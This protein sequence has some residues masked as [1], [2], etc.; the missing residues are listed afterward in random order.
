MDSLTQACLGALIGAV[1]APAAQRRRG[2]LYGAALGTLPD[3]DVLIPYANP[4]DALVQ[5]R[6][7]SHS[8][9][10]LTLLAPVLHWLCARFDRALKD[11]A[12][13]WRLLFLLALIT[14]PL[15]D[16]FT[17][18]GTQLLWPFDRTPYALASIFIIDP[19]VTLPMLLALIWVARAP[20]LPAILA[21]YVALAWSCLYLVF[22]LL[23]QQLIR[24]R[25]EASLA[26]EEAVEERAIFV[27]A[28]P[29]TGLL[30][31]VVVREPTLFREGYV[32]LWADAGPQWRS[33]E[34]LDLT[35]R[36]LRNSEDFAKLQ[37]F[38]D[39][40]YWL[41]SDGSQLLYSDLRM[42]SMPRFV[43]NY[44]L[45]EFEQG[46]WKSTPARQLPMQ[47]PSLSALPWIFQRIYTPA[48]ELPP[49][50]QIVQGSAQ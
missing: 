35:E 39:G 17:S 50:D 33:F 29:F 7:F 18:Y 40:F 32:S 20:R 21:S 47:R 23:A 28:A 19:M 30:W 36:Y 15:L 48:E 11:T 14:H 16:W 46:A 8:L 38:S 44:A 22:G 12:A 9:F 3:L 27:S 49:A 26:L 10:V 6:S 5:H 41:W 24:Q 31:R 13:A 43:F 37:Y 1:G 45:A 34:S 4:V 2:M 25:V 42:G